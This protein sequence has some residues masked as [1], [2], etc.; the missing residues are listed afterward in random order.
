VATTAADGGA[1]GDSTRDELRLLQEIVAFGTRF[2][3]GRDPER[4]LRAALRLAL[5]FFDA[6]EGCVA[7]A[8]PDADEVAI[9]FSL[10]RETTWDRFAL[11]QF[12]RGDKVR[13]PEDEMIARIRRRGRKWGVL[14]VR[15][16]SAGFRWDARRAL[17][18]IASAATE[19]VARIDQER[20]RE[21][22]S[23]I[24]RKIM[25]QLRPK[26]LFYQILHGIRS[27]TDYDHS[28][29]LLMCDENLDAMEVVAEQIAWRKGK[30]TAVGRRL[31][32]DDTVRGLL[33]PE[34]VYGFHRTP[35]GW[36]EW[37][38]RDAEPLA[39]LLDH[40][41]AV[42]ADGDGTAPC[43]AA[44]ICAPL[45]SRDAVLG[46][47]KVAACGRGTLSDYETNLVSRFLPQVSVALQNSQRA[48]SLERKILDAE[49]KHAMADL[50]RGV[51]HDVNNALGCVLPLV[52][53]MHDDACAG[54][55]DPEVAKGDLREIQRSLEVCRRIFRG[56][57]GFA[58][59]A[60]RHEGRV[61]LRP[62]VDTT[63]DILRDGMARRDI[64]VVVNVPRDLPGILGIQSDVEQLLLNLLTNA[65]DAMPEGGRVTITA[66]A[67]D[68]MIVLVIDDTGR[69]IPDSQLPKIQE[70]FFTT[71]P[72]GHGLGLAI[73][74]SIVSQMG[75][76][77]EFTSAP[78]AGT[79]VTV[80]LRA[81]VEDTV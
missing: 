74:R 37:E 30:S 54:T 70:P 61:P 22:R 31:A 42:G 14:A 45:V 80:R 51:S 9:L 16:S 39:V 47:L 35:T 38:G 50:A 79:R 8:P 65:R 11:A 56:M 26:D 41:P 19:V 13:F 58:R 46:V 62:E 25:E 2:R 3:D 7:V 24:D 10:P 1:R 57:L 23:R 69:G 43:E 52:E 53:E 12:V 71:K 64:E 48:E 4:A 40:G 59:G 6:S 28:S 32:I 78:G 15:A 20:I 63:L 75:G 17:S 44:M 55:L 81:A 5:D 33:R 68:D 34:T 21:V 18:A 66:S 60:A 77:L 72:E 73:C 27:L 49:R 29:A 76:R 36:A 67:D